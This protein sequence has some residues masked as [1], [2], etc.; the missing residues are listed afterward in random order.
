MLLKI[1]R[2]E[3]NVSNRDWILDN[4]ACYQCMTLKYSVYD[5]RLYENRSQ[6]QVMSKKMFKELLKKDQLIEVFDIPMRYKGC[7]IWRF[8]FDEN[9]S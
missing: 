4:G 3:Y 2:N 9:N 8:N 7:R 6:V 1:G 5:P